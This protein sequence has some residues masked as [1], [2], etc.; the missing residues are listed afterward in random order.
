MAKHNSLELSG[1]RFTRLVA[2]SRTERRRRGLVV[3]ECVCDCGEIVHVT[4]TNLNLGLTRSCGCYQKDM[5]REA[6]TKHGRARTPEYRAWVDLK[7]RCTSSSNSRW[8]GYGGRGIKV[9]DRWLESFENFYADMGDRPSVKHSIDRI[10]NDGDYCPENCQWA[11]P[12]E[13]YSNRSTNR[14]LTYQGRT[15]NV[16]EWSAEIGISREV[17]YNRLSKG[18]SEERALTTPLKASNS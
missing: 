5:Q 2:V 8:E 1:K 10:D 16:T 17:L 7:T 13:Q 9:C 11:T 6:I 3:W 15:L 14:Y 4:S 12:K 18:W